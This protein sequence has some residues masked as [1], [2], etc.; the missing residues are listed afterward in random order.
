MEILRITEARHYRGDSVA[1]QKDI[2]RRVGMDISSVN[3][4]LNRKK[5][6]IFK[7]GTIEKVMRTAESLGFDFGR[8]KHDHRRKFERTVLSIP[9]EISIVMP[10][11]E[12]HDRGIAAIEDLSLGG[13]KFGR[14]KL[15]SGTFPTGPF[16][17]ILRG[18]APPFQGIELRGRLIRIEYSRD[19][20]S[21]C[22]EFDTLD[23]GMGP[24]L[25]RLSRRS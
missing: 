11:G 9:V 7:K 2:A 12:I 5:G 18:A 4:I 22:I 3:K 1:T 23:H 13:V 8:L 16:S 20:S 25:R 6:P 17:V 21:F 15:P 19:G 14:V 24:T 10:G